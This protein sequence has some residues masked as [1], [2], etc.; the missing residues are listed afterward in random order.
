ML[1]VTAVTRTQGFLNEIEIIPLPAQGAVLIEAR[2]DPLRADPRLFEVFGMSIPQAL[3]RMA[4]KRAA[5]FLAGRLVAALG[6]EALGVAPQE[7]VIGPGRAPLWPAGLAGSIT[8]SGQRCAC[9]VTRRADLICGIDLEHIAQGAALRAIMDRCL[10]GPERMLAQQGLGLPADQAAT[11]MF[12]AKET[13][14]KALYPT[15]GRIFGFDAAE[16]AR[17]LE[18]RALLL[19]LTDALHPTLPAGLALAPRYILRADHLL[20]LIIAPRPAF[21]AGDSTDGSGAGRDIAR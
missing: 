8:H 21:S 7:I 19:H 20:T 10:S 16:V 1:S 5:E 2:F 11:L 6:A 17:D 15:V 9:L 3:D 13:I 4:D 18:G 14:F 12:S